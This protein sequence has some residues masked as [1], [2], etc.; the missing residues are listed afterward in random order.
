MIVLDCRKN[1]LSSL[2][3]SANVALEYLWCGYNNISTLDVTSNTLLEGLDCSWM[4]EQISS[5]DLSNNTALD[6]IYCE[7]SGLS[8]L[9]VSNQPDLNEFIGGGN[10]F[11]TFDI[12]NNPALEQLKLN[13]MPS[14][15]EVC[16]WSTPFPPAWVSVDTTGS[17]NIVFTTACN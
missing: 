11:S 1:E 13:Q 16:V 6:W 8:S 14:L 4:N 12:S 9:D 17:P 2:D 15:G 7:H 10:L 3:V 5:L